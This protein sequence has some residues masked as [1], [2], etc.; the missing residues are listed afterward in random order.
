MKQE[1]K[2]KKLPLGKVTVEDLSIHLDDEEQSKIKGGS[3]P[4]P[5]G[6]T[7]IPIFC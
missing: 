2:D 5:A 3:D 7:N 4:D 1:Q 6:T